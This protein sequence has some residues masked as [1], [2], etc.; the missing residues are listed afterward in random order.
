[1]KRYIYFLSHVTFYIDDDDQKPIDFKGE[2]ISLTCQLNKKIKKWMNLKM[3]RP[4][5]E[6]EDIFLSF[7]K[8]CETLIKQN[9]RKAEETLKF[10]VSQP[11]ETY[12][13]K[14]SITIEEFRTLGLTILE[15]YKSNFDI[16]H[17]KK[18]NSNFIQTL[19]TNFHL[20]N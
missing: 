3:M 8:N 2:T 10:K 19:L 5:T 7:T 9:H 14:P 12:S 1:M 20:K 13:F 16:T 15:V 17:E 4:E 6:T 11:E 18:T